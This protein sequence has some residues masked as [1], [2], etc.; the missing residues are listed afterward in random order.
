M[1]AGTVSQPTFTGTGARLVTDN[2]AVPKT[3]TST[4]SGGSISATGTFTPEGTVATSTATTANKTTTVSKAASG[5]TTF[6]PE[7][8]INVTLTQTNTNATVSYS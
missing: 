2:I 5:D 3:Y 8:T 4:F 6:T 1:P 7:G